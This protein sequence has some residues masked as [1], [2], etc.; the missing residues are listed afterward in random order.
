MLLI[1]RQCHTISY[2]VD[3][4]LETTRLLGQP[5]T[6]CNPTEGYTKGFCEFSYVMA[7]VADTCLCVPGY[8]PN[9]RSIINDTSLPDCNYYTHA[10]CVSYIRSSFDPSVANCLPGCISSGYKRFGI[11]V[12]TAPQEFQGSTA[13]RFLQC[14]FFVVTIS[15][16]YNRT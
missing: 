6:A 10:S 15:F 4:K 13:R 11:E 7:H 12:A 3:V 5:F 9:I 16:R 8:I 14:N 1:N 2:Q